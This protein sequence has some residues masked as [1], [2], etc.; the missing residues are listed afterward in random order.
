MVFAGCFVA[1]N[2]VPEF[3]HDKIEIGILSVLD[4]CAYLVCNFNVGKVTL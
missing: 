4:L 2:I 1:R 3:I